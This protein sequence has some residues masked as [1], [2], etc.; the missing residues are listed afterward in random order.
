M[1]IIKLIIGFSN[2]GKTSYSEQFKNVFHL[3]QAFSIYE[4]P[5]KG[6]IVIEGVYLRKKMRKKILDAIDK[7][8]YE[9]ICIWIDTPIEIC[10]EREH[11][12]RK[13]PDALIYSQAISFQPPEYDEGWDKIIIIRNGK[14]IELKK[15]EQEV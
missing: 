6:D 13:R 2:S 14:T 1:D 12:G 5:Q 8:K 9:K 7:N 15:P 4:L 10:I 3:D 11:E